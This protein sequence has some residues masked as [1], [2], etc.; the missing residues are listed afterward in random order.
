M[1]SPGYVYC[2]RVKEDSLVGIGKY[3]LGGLTILVE[4]FKVGCSDFCFDTVLN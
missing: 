3:L 4:I 1:L 2:K